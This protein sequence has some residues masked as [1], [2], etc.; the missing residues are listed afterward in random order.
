MCLCL[1]QLLAP[2]PQP[3]LFGNRGSVVSKPLPKWP[4]LQGP[5]HPGLM[6]FGT[7][8]RLQGGQDLQSNQVRK[9]NGNNAKLRGCYFVD[10][11]HPLVFC[12]EN[13]NH[14]V[15]VKETPPYTENEYHAL[16][17]CLYGTILVVAL[18]GTT[19]LCIYPLAHLP[20]CPVVEQPPVGDLPVSIITTAAAVLQSTSRK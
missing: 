3:I 11:A 14:K 17:N 9:Y 10:F 15:H 13:R 20:Q 6:R 8:R 16:M 2:L 12:F 5:G 4:V 19:R 7:R 1:V 18:K